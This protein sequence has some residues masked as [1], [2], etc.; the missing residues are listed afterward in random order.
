[1]VSTET[2]GSVFMAEAAGTISRV[3]TSLRTAGAECLTCS[4]CTSV[5]FSSLVVEKR[6]ASFLGRRTAVPVRDP[7]A[8]KETK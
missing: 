8:K 1:M 2:L 3:Y 7:A 6:V 5:V 4:L